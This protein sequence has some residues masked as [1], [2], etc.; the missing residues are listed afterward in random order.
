MVI[1]HI[2]QRTS[3]CVS[4]EGTCQRFAF[5]SN[6]KRALW[7]TQKPWKMLIVQ[8]QKKATHLDGVSSP[9]R[10]IAELNV[11]DPQTWPSPLPNNSFSLS[12]ACQVNDKGY[13][14]RYH[15][16]DKNASRGDHKN[17]K[18]WP[19]HFMRLP[20]ANAT[21]H[22]GLINYGGDG[23]VAVQWQ[24]TAVAIRREERDCEDHIWWR[25]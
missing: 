10:S 22:R 1:K 9:W 17:Q 12:S 15:W 4:F 11:N 18:E 25:R 7:S 8:Q 6:L 13:L 23:P 20:F 21:P 5:S 2:I 3:L 16:G 14:G 24:C 19:Y